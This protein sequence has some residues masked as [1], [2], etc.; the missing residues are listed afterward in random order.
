MLLRL[1]LPLIVL[2]AGTETA[3][4]DVKPQTED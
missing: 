1:H 3:T 2:E 4:A